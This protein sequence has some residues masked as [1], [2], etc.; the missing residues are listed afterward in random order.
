MTT[1][2][3]CSSA[4]DSDFLPDAAKAR[5]CAADEVYVSVASVWEI[6]IKHALGKAGMPVSAEEASQAFD[7]AGYLSLPVRREHALRLATLPPL[8]RDPFDRLLVAQALSEPLTLLTRDR[9]MAGYSDAIVI[10]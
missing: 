2:A 4:V 9:A 8:H 5:I 3:A 10:V 1:C 6:A 7:D